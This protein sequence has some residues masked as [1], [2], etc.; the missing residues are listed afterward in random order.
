M[1]KVINVGKKRIGEENRCFI[2]AEAG[3]NHNGSLSMAK[4]L[5]N[6]AFEAGADAVKFQTFRSEELVTNNAGMAEYQEKNTKRKEAQ[7]KMLK[8]LELKYDDFIELK[9]YCDKKG[10][11]FLATPHSESAIDFLEKLVPLYKVA[12]G[13]LNNLPLLKKIAQK[14]KPII[15]SSGMADMDEIV[16]ALKVIKEVGNNQVILLH[17]TT[18]YPCP[19]QEVNMKAMATMQKKFKCLVGYSDHTEGIIVPILAVAYEAAVIEKHFTL[20]KNLPGPDH[21]ASLTPK[22]LKEMVE[23]VRNAQSALGNSIKKPTESEKKIK[24]VARK[25]IIARIAIK[26]GTTILEG[27]LSI[28]RPGTG[29]E[30]KYLSQIVGRTARKNIKRDEMLKRNQI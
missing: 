25:S 6:V 16:Q 19:F 3:V 1:E 15:I 27:M 5:V 30:P 2:I 9:R 12:S 7:I 29:I 8:R 11:L 18:N 21:K 24:K 26:K 22:E 14:K 10:I 17:C 4:K 28:K 23:A 13:D 20:D